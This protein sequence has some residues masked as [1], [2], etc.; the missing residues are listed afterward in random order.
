MGAVRWGETVT[1]RE[2]INVYV[3]HEIGTKLSRDAKLFEVFKNDHRT[4]NRNWFLTRLLCGYHDDYLKEKKVVYDQVAA[5]LK[6]S[7]L[8]AYEICDLASRIRDEVFLPEI[9]KRKGKKPMCLSLKPTV[10]TERILL[11]VERQLEGGDYI[12]QFICRMFTS[13]CQKPISERERIVFKDEYEYL[14]NACAVGHSVSFSIIWD[15]NTRHEVMPYALATGSE[16]MFNYLLCEEINLK[17][18]LP[19]ARSYRLNRIERLS[20]GKRTAPIT[21]TVKKR[22]ARTIS[23]APQYA[24]NADEEICVRLN[25]AGEKLYNRI[26]YGRPDYYRIEDRKD[27]HYYFFHCSSMQAFHYFRRFDNMTAVVVF[28]PLLRERM[29]T[30]HENALR[31]YRQSEGE[32]E[33]V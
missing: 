25:D 10:E 32:K 14:Q 24:I 4:I 29:S 27:G 22:C 33:D 9:P 19:E 8:E 15:G 16:E 21:P 6:S 18:G 11:D 20:Y 1:Y 17:T 5:I 28:P 30:F 12:S 23:V 31:A 3:P 7:T 26:Y 13:Y 2:K